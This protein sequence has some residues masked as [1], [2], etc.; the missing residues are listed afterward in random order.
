M[1]ADP[2]ELLRDKLRRSVNIIRQNDAL[3]RTGAD[4]AHAIASIATDIRR[5]P[6]PIDRAID[7]MNDVVAARAASRTAANLDD[8][9]IDQMIPFPSRWL[10]TRAVYGVEHACIWPP[11]PG[12]T[13]EDV[14]AECRARI[15]SELARAGH[16]TYDGN[17]LVALRQAERALERLV[18]STVNA[19]RR[20]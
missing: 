2:R 16:W 7:R 18:A 20:M 5:T 10:I 13:A 15:A 11:R 9:V 14:L 12:M 17:R 1:N 4:L 3:K 8:A 6:D 19:G